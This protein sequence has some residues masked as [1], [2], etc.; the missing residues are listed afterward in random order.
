MTW[1]SVPNRAIGYAP[2]EAD[3]D[4]SIRDNL[5][6]GAWVTVA[7]TK[8]TGTAAAITFSSI[9]GT[10]AHLRVVA[11][12]RGDAAVV[13]QLTNLRF[14]GDTAA[15]YDRQSIAGAGASALSTESFAQTSAYVG[16]GPGAS[17]PSNLFSIHEITIPHYANA[18]NNKVGIVASGTK[19]GTST[20]NISA[21]RTAIFW[22]SNAA[23]T[24]ITILPAAGNLVAG[25][26]ATLLALP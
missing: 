11:Y 1:T 14:N 3:W 7:T 2:V 13:S 15:N 25:S 19:I 23:I 8:L 17:A 6:V 9:T 26:V 12:L 5:N 4:T 16:D 10:F 20:G 24:S 18:T 22:R 21:Y